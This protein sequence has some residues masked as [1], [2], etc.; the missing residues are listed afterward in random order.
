MLE[1]ICVEGN[2]SCFNPDLEPVPQADGPD[3]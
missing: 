2:V 3:S 1:V